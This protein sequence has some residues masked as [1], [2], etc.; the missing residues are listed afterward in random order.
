MNTNKKE[1]R[2]KSGQFYGMELITGYH[3]YHAF[4]TDHKAVFRKLVE[5]YNYNAQSGYNSATFRKLCRN[6]EYYVYLYK[7]DMDQAFGFDD[8]CMSLGCRGG[9]SIGDYL[10][11]LD[12][13]EI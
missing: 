11:M 8:D 3:R 10:D 7:F 4:G 6:D 2:L 13:K 5:L 12:R 9:I 1:I